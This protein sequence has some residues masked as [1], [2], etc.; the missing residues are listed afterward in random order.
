[1]QEFDDYK[2]YIFVGGG[3]QWQKGCILKP[4]RKIENW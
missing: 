4:K 1:M 3:G 2:K